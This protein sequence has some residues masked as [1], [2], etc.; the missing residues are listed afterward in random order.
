MKIKIVSEM[1]ILPEYES[2][3]SAGMDLSAAEDY[4]LEAG[5]RKLIRTGIH[6]ELPQGYEAQIR[7]RSGLAINKGIGLV[8]G[9]GTIDSDYRGEIKLILINWSDLPFRITK[10]DRIGQMVISK[11][12]KV[13]WEEVKDVKELGGSQRGSGGFGSSGL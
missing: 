1:G 9:I 4:L 10:G 13:Q 11:Y 7:A 12:E 6:I 5:Q 8:N 3:G 2:F